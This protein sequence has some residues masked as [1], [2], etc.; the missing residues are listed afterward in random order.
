VKENRNEGTSEALTA[1][2]AQTQPCPVTEEFPGRTNRAV[3]AAAAY[4]LAKNAE[5]YRRLAQ[6]PPAS[7]TKRVELLGSVRGRHSG[8]TPS[9]GTRLAV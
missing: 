7:E 5:L 4:V 2:E 6:G 8:Q 1:P 3:N 9:R